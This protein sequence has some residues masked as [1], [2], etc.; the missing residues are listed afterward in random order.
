M[1]NRTAHDQIDLSIIVPA[2]NE[3]QRIEPTLAHLDDYLACTDASYE[4]LVVDDGSVD[5]TAD[6]VRRMQSASSQPPN[7]PTAHVTM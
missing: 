4:I 7:Q 6:L 1:T 3:E 5:G 2:Y